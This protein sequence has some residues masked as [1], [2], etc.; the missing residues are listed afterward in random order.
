MKFS[1]H[2]L[3]FICLTMLDRE[4]QLLTVHTV[5]IA[6]KVISRIKCS[7]LIFYIVSFV[8]Q[9]SLL[10]RTSVVTKESLLEK[11]CLQG[12]IV[13]FKRSVLGFGVYYCR[14]RIRYIL[15]SDE[16]ASSKA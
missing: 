7:D 10:F 1:K 3:T 16:P 11:L 2:C 13:R 4:A 6:V 5:P 12:L 14:Y 9:A 15:M 8:V